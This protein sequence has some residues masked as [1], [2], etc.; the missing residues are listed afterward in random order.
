MR[1]SKFRVDSKVFK[2]VFRP[3]A[4]ESVGAEK[5]A[6]PTSVRRAARHAFCFIDHNRRKSPPFGREPPQPV[7]LF[8][9]REIAVPFLNQQLG[10][11]E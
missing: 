8:F 2:I 9:V 11:R 4:D 5:T 1:F 10:R 6:K 3:K 7:E